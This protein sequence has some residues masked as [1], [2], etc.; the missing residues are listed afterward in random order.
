[1]SQSVVETM[2][3]DIHDLTSEVVEH[4]R[5]ATRRTSEDANAAFHRSSEVLSRAA[6][7]LEARGR[8]TSRLASRQMMTSVQEHPLTTTAIIA[9]I[10]I[11]LALAASR[12]NGRG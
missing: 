11:L 5:D 7:R 8:E 9:S 6:H 10:A 4:L 1:M 3:R 2:S 12:V